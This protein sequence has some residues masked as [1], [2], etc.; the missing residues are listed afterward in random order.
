MSKTQGQCSRLYLTATKPIKEIREIRKTHRNKPIWES[1]IFK[2]GSYYKFFFSSNQSKKVSLC[3]DG[4]NLEDAFFSDVASVDGD[5]HSWQAGAVN[6]WYQLVTFK[7]ITV[8]THP[9]EFI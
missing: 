5:T 1:T 6:E 7:E 3:E 9:E 8:E 4:G 2:K